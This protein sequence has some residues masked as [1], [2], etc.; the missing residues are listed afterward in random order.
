VR[1]LRELCCLRA[2]RAWR[3]R[4]KEDLSTASAKKA[5]EVDDEEE[6]DDVEDDGDDDEPGAED[7]DFYWDTTNLKDDDNYLGEDVFRVE[8]IRKKRINE[9][10]TEFLIKWEGWAEADNTWEARAGRTQNFG[11]R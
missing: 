5:E 10:V 7:G 2:E 6:D 4:T 9:G 11:P 1:P 3:R 8:A